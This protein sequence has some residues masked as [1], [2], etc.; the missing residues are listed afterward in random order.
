ML[1][2]GLKKSGSVGVHSVALVRLVELECLPL[3]QGAGMIE[4]SPHNEPL[5]Q[6]WQ[7]VPPAMAWYLAAS[8]RVHTLKPHPAA[9]VPG[10]H[11]V[12]ATLPVWL[13]EPGAVEVH[14][15]A[16]VKLVELEY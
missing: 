15:A 6:N 9:T 12:S 14:S 5:T 2:V 8:H 4:P 3:G 7:A 10:A 1:P 11:G 13:D 16:L